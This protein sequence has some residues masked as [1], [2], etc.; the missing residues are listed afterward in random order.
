VVKKYPSVVIFVIWDQPFIKM[1][2]SNEDVICRIRAWW[3]ERRNAYG[4]FC[5]RRTP[6]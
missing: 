1:V 4:V 2:E 6:L 5:D 3:F